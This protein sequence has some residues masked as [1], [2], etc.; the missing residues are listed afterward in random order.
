MGFWKL[1][2]DEYEKLRHRFRTRHQPREEAQSSANS[3]DSGPPHSLYPEPPA[4]GVTASAGGY[5][6]LITKNLHPSHRTRGE[7]SRRA[8]VH[9]PTVTQ[10]AHHPQLGSLPECP[11]TVL[12]VP[13]SQP[14]APLTECAGYH[15]LITRQLP[16]TTSAP[17]LV[18]LWRG[19]EGFRGRLEAPTP[20]PSRAGS[21]SSLS[22]D[23]HL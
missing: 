7:K 14:A 12:T 2:W 5:T 19:S 18:E 21:Q 3:E 10:V 6:T 16:D 22:R 8:Q 17:S 9:T 13:L 11:T 20:V 4:A 23:H 15:G 1:V